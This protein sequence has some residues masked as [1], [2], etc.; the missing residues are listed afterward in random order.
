[1]REMGRQ[2]RAEYELK[3]TAA[4]NYEMLISIYEGVIAGRRKTTV[5][6]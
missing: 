6:A 2:A 1:M 3:Y 4:K 5:T